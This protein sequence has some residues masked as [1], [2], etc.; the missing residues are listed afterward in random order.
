MG[1]NWRDTD[2]F[3]SELL[4]VLSSPIADELHAPL[5][6]NNHTNGPSVIINNVGDDVRHEGIWI[7]D[8]G[9]PISGSDDSTGDGN[10]QHVHLGIGLGSIGIISN[11]MIPHP[12]FFIDP[13]VARRAWGNVA[14][15]GG[16]TTLVPGA[17][18]PY[19]GVA[20]GTG[21]VPDGGYDQSDV[22]AEWD[23][24]VGADHDVGGSPGTVVGSGYGQGNSGTGFIDSRTVN[25]GG[26]S[27]GI[28]FN[29][30]VARPIYLG[31]PT[32]TISKGSTGTIRRWAGVIGSEYVTSQYIY[33]VAARAQEVTSSDF[34]EVYYVDG[35]GWQCNLAEC[36]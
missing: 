27:V 15:Q 14:G 30:S 4:R 7:T 20:P 1:R 22:D 36:A 10:G 3:A 8:G 33:S 24:T 26:P 11:E 28:V 18:G 16:S 29:Q 35:V 25:I 31:K 2:E 13:E 19:P 9:V 21:A 32:A 17:P 23:G 12:S 5:V 34:V 6:F